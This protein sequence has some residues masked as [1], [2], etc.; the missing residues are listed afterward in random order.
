MPRIP[1]LS[2]YPPEETA[3]LWLPLLGSEIRRH[4]S[5]RVS[6]PSLGLSPGWKS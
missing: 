3:K 1:L 6:G 4:Q 5:S 2:N